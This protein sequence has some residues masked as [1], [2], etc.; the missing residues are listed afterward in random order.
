MKKNKVKE[1]TRPRSRDHKNTVQKANRTQTD[2]TSE[3]WTGKKKFRCPN[4]RCRGEEGLTKSE[5]KDW[6]SHTTM[7]KKGPD[8]G[9]GENKPGGASPLNG[10]ESLLW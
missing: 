9:G 5:K 6:V 1:F 8:D 10:P 3:I 2:K 4:N 7:F